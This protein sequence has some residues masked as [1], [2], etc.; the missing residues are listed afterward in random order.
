MRLLQYKL[1]IYTLPGTL[2][3]TFTPSPDPGLGIRCVSWHPSGSF[4]AVGGYDDKIHIIDSLS[5]SAVTALD[6]TSKIP[7]A[8]VRT[9]TSRQSDLWSQ[10]SDASIRT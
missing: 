5:W 8:V 9:F 3:S 6:L 1:C 4:I 10:L 7:A 2:L